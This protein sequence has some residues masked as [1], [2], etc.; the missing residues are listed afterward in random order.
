MKKDIDLIREQLRQD[1]TRTAGGYLRYGLELFH[2]ERSRSSSCIQPPIGNLGIAV[3]LMLKT[4]L[5]KNNPILLFDLPI[6][7]RVMFVSPDTLPKDF[8]L[9]RYDIKLRSFAFKTVKLQECTKAFFF[10]FPNDKQSLQPYFNILSR[11]RNASVHASLP[12]FQKYDMEKMAYLALQVF[13]ILNASETFKPQSYSLSEKDEKFLSSFDKERT[14]K[15][16]KKIEKAKEKAEKI[17]PGADLVKVEGWNRY[18]AECPICRSKG[19]LTGY[20]DISTEEDDTTSASTRLEFYASSFKCNVCGLILD[21][22]EELH[23]AGMNTKY[24]RSTEL[25]QWFQDKWHEDNEPSDYYD[26][27]EYDEPPPGYDE[28]PPGY[29][30]PPPGYDEPPPGYD[31]PPPGYDEPPPGYD[32][33]PPDYEA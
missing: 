1:L 20:S 32:E 2:K 11:C 15:V 3:E 19:V 31:E 18:T 5:V 6:E 14:E 30:E 28:P 12:S 21:D 16:H 13:K 33:P 8:N 29:D 24:D 9:R 23:L 4:F 17:T 27:I 25:K 22:M 7:L 26:V 10:F